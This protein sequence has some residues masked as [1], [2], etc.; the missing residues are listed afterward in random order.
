MYSA[1][2]FLYFSPALFL[3]T[4]HFIFKIK[5]TDNTMKKKQRETFSIVFSLCTGKQTSVRA[6]R[7]RKNIFC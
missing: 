5:D 3:S 1:N 6:L 7:S 2:V 4:I